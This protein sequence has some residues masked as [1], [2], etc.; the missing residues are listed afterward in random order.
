MIR[1]AAALIILSVANGGA[2]DWPAYGKDPARSTVTDESLTFPLT[3][4][5]VYTSAQPPSPAWPEPGVE[6]SR[7]DFDKAFQP[8]VAEGLL[9]FGSSADD[10]VQ[11]LDVANGHMR[12]RFTAG[13]PI[14]FAPHLKA[15]R[16]FF[17][18]D[19]G[20]NG[21]ELWKVEAVWPP[22]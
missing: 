9:F 16:C 8:V 10:T 19:D 17:A 20:T 12:W 22:R 1:S 3:E 21:R 18:A 7:V 13:G 6:M 14:R 11:A 15:G 5:W 2:D 4:A